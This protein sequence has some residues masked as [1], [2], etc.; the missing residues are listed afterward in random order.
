MGRLPLPERHCVSQRGTAEARR[1]DVGTGIDQQVE[2]GDVV[3]ARGPVERRLR[4]LARAQSVD[5]GT[6]CDQCNNR[7]RAIREMAGPIGGDM[8]ERS[9]ADHCR[10]QTSM[11]GEQPLE[12]GQIASLDSFH[13]VDSERVVGREIR[14]RRLLV[15][16]IGLIDGGRSRRRTFRCRLPCR[17]P[18]GPTPK[19]RKGN[20]HHHDQHQAL[21]NGTRH[22]SSLI[23][24]SIG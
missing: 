8:Q 6:G 4:A 20:G 15:K 23:R 22:T 1:L 13:N 24:P 21:E 17:R 19:G 12:R 2:H 3:T 10:G 7:R 5:I 18:F 16:L 9:R 14:F 11:L